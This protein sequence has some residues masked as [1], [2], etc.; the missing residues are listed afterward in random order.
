MYQ[1]SD[2]AILI[3]FVNL[4][5]LEV[6]AEADFVGSLNKTIFLK[7]LTEKHHQS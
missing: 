3:A 2:P 5:V 4:A 6:T 1:S 7:S